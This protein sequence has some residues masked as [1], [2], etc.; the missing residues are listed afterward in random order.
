MKYI[1]AVCAILGNSQV[2][3]WGVAAQP[4]NHEPNVTDTGH[5]K[6][7]TQ[8]PFIVPLARESIP[9]IRRNVTVSHKTSYS[10]VISIGKPA[11]EFRVV[12]DTGS[13]HIVVPSKTCKNQTCLQHRQYDVEASTTG[14]PVNGD[15]TLVPEDELADQVTIG[16]GTGSVKGEF[17]EDIVC[18]GEPSDEH[19]APCIKTGLIMAVEMTDNPFQSFHF[20]GIFGLALHA[21]AMSAEF[22]FLSRLAG[23]GDHPS[24]QFGVFLTHEEGDQSEIALGGHNA[25]KLLSPLTWVTV[26]QKEMGY[27]QAFLTEVRFAGKILESCMDGTCRAIVDTGTSHIGVPGPDL[28]E[29]VH[30]LSVDTYEQ[31]GDCRQQKDASLELEFVFAGGLTLKL[32]PSDYMRPMSLQAGTN[33]GLSNGK[34]VITGGRGNSTQDPPTKQMATG[35]DGQIAALRTCTPRMM[36]VNLP[37]PLGPKLFILGEPLLQ[38]YY[39]VYDS[40]EQQI[41]FGLAANSENRRAIL[42]GGETFLT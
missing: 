31:V 29:L 27:W 41:G 28:R 22:S 20:D 19:S 32:A 39:T 35:A 4:T 38:K 6:Y 2:D 7:A 5:T 1:M 25:N 36:P 9:V 12:F 24:Q 13:A 18:P 8:W 26:A 40:V 42:N 10:G 23:S 16:Y 34:P 37:A 11:Q 21:L 30:T 17:A 15:G 3:T 14:S 33:V